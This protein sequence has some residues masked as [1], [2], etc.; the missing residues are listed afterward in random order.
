M[1]SALQLVHSSV[2]HRI[3]KVGK[4][5]Q[6]H[7]NQPLGCSSQEKKHGDA[8]G[9]VKKPAC[10]IVAAVISY[11]FPLLWWMEILWEFVRREKKSTGWKKRQRIESSYFQ[12]HAELRGCKDAE[13]FKIPI[14][15]SVGVFCAALHWLHLKEALSNMFLGA[16]VEVKEHCLPGFPW[17]SNTILCVGMSSSE[18]RLCILHSL[19][20]PAYST[21]CLAGALLSLLVVSAEQSCSYLFV[22]DCSLYTSPL[23]QWRMGAEL[24]YKDSKMIKIMLLKGSIRSTDGED[25]CCSVFSQPQ[26]ASGT[27]QGAGRAFQAPQHEARAPSDRPSLPACD[28]ACS[29]VLIF[30]V[31]RLKFQKLNTSMSDFFFLQDAAKLMFPL[32]TVR[33]FAKIAGA[34]TRGEGCPWQSSLLSTHPAAR[35][36]SLRLLCTE[37]PPLGCKALAGEHPSLWQ[38]LQEVLPASSLKISFMELTWLLFSLVS[39]LEWVL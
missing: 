5:R 6:D 15:V 32:C 13:E 35:P 1:P 21:V 17:S 3:I 19:E 39:L 23:T 7:W 8:G 34:G 36:V 10:S 26:V 37:K 11:S 2:G 30:R 12:T 9:A 29:T 33:C 38:H 20:F 24:T 14:S 18:C 31:K 27:T 25:F 28:L 22:V 16:G 4:D